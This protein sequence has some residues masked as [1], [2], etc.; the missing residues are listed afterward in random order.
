MEKYGTARE[1]TDDVYHTAQA[2]CML[3]NKRYGTL[4]ICK[5]FL[6]LYGNN[7]CTNAPQHYVYT[8]TTCL[9]YIQFTGG[10][11]WNF[12]N[13]ETVTVTYTFRK[14]YKETQQICQ[15]QWRMLQRTRKNTI[16]RPS[17][18]VR[19]ACSITVFTRERMFMLFMC[20]K[21]F[22]LLIRESL[23]IDFTK[24]RLF[25]LFKFICTVYKS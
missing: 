5:Y 19:M 13:S 17:T 14:H 12:L 3:D 18:R 16:G 21:M 10:K 9:V 22:M 15:L 25:M 20:V 6:L 7:G 4:T 1:A 2:L 11:G 24:E 23:F 8:Y